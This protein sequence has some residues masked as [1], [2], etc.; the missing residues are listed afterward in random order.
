[1]LRRKQRYR[2]G[3]GNDSDLCWGY[4]P[5]A[6]VSVEQFSPLLRGSSFLLSGIYLLPLVWTGY[7]IYTHSIV[8]SG[9]YEC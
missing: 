2:T 4:L 1:M 8:S 5:W 6:A 3:L 9:R 7:N